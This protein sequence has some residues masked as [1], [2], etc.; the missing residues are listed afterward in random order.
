[1]QKVK[2][3]GHSVY[4]LEWNKRTDRQT[5]RRTIALPPVLMRSVTKTY[6]AAAVW[7]VM[8]AVITRSLTGG[9]WNRGVYGLRFQSNPTLP[10]SIYTYPTRSPTLYDPSPPI[11]VKISF[12]R[13]PCAPVLVVFV[14][15]PMSNSQFTPPPHDGQVESCRAVW[16]GY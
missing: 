13:H 2:I 8:P 6:S 12:R 4:K 10:S 14:V 9:R 7:S 16:I 5:D 3:K 15:R 11:S 1:M